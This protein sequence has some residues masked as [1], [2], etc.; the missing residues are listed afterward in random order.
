MHSIKLAFV[1]G[2]MVMLFLGCGADNDQKASEINSGASVW[3]GTYRLSRMK[4][5]L[6]AVHVKGQ[7]DDVK[8]GTDTVDL[9][10]YRVDLADSE[11][12]LSVFGFTET[13]RTG[14]V[15]LSGAGS[16]GI[17]EC[18]I[19]TG[20]WLDCPLRNQRV[21]TEKNC[22]YWLALQDAAEIRD[23]K[24]VYGRYYWLGPVGGK[25][26]L[27][28]L[29]EELPKNSGISLWQLVFDAKAF[30]ITSLAE[31]DA[32][33]VADYYQAEKQR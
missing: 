30:V 20:N 19:R 13:D 18:K 28:K 29:Q 16:N 22:Q 11:L 24:L 14:G 31:V 15:K 8:Q 5:T 27:S 32:A 2:F 26:C 21:E 6:G 12:T 25:E 33:V 9:A 10:K 7:G 23:G 17:R 3:E 1:P 4:K